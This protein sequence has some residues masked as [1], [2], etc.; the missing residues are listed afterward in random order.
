MNLH[1]KRQHLLAYEVKVVQ[2]YQRSREHFLEKIL[3]LNRHPQVQFFAIGI[4]TKRRLVF[5]AALRWRTGR[6]SKVL[7]IALLLRVAGVAELWLW[8]NLIL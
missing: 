4:S 7:T 1:L 8:R 2:Q 6:C 5:Y 3:V